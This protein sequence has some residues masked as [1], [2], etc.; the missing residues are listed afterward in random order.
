MI[1]RRALGGA[2]LAVLAAG[3]HGQQELPGKAPAQQVLSGALATQ[4]GIDQGLGFLLSTQNAD[5]SWGGVKNAT[6]TSAFGNPATYHSWQVGT[7]SLVVITL[8]EL[9][10]NADAER[11]IDRGLDYLMANARLVRP[12][13][14]DVDN[15]WGLIYNLTALTTALQQPRFREGERSIAIREAAT[16]ALNGLIKYQSPRGGWGYYA[17]A[18]SAWRPEWATSFTTAAG[19]LALVEARNAGLAVED[20]VF[21]AAVRAVEM[22]RLPTGAYSYDVSPVPRHP[23][24]ESID[25]VKGSLGRIQACN[26]ALYEAGA[27]LPEGALER[28]LELFFEHHK[29]LDAARNKPIPHE[30]YYAN[31]AYF[32]LFGHY[33][34]A[35]VLD[36]LPKAARAR[37]VERLQHEI[38]KCQQK[39]GSIWDF[40]IASN[41]KAFG[42]AFGVMALARTLPEPE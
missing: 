6:F 25:N 33:Y 11:A 14:W 9:G 5:G 41:T 23:R 16:T 27:E 8:M 20:K 4:R 34:A 38:L 22:C 39:D 15:V 1:A 13:D 30:A 24:M 21:R 40:W 7:S 3:A 18:E 2:A 26:Y 29:F 36:V 42:T 12:A 19:L 37:F 10:K 35:K 31:A 32:Y 28:G 17:D